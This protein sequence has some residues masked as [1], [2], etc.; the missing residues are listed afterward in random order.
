MEALLYCEIVPKR[1]LPHVNRTPNKKPYESYY[2]SDSAQKTS[3][4][5]VGPFMK[6]HKIKF[7]EYWRYTKTPLMATVLFKILYLFRQLIW[8]RNSMVEIK[9]PHVFSDLRKSKSEVKF[10]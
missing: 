4:Y 10:F 8:R 5:I 3:M 7:P 6:E 2:Q 1:P 9:D